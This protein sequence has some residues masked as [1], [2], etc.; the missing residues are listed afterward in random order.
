[1]GQDGEMKKTKAGAKS[2]PR[3]S[4]VREVQVPRL[5][6]DASTGVPEVESCATRIPEGY[7]D[8]VS[9][10]VATPAQIRRR[11]HDLG[12]ALQRDFGKNEWVVV[13]LLNGSVLFVADLIREL[14]GPL[15][16]D[17]IGVSSY[18][19]GTESGKLVY[20]K[21]LKF[22]VTGRRVLVVDDI[23][24]TGRTLSAVIRKL[25]DLGAREVRMCV[26]LDKPA[27]R[28]VKQVADYVGFTIPDWFVVGYG[29]DYAERYRHLP[30][31][32][33]L[34]PEVVAETA[35]GTA[36]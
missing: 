1:M 5:R 21:E 7:E 9:G 8:I 17:F 24:D 28:Q 11:I 4:Q 34:R 33:V 13:A 2:E 22:E 16:L 31:I 25:K 14:E 35:R 32:G 26:L 19:G 20:T 6:V 10:V 29:L 12:R 18:G 27:R 15:I 3:A 30:F 36:R 23:L